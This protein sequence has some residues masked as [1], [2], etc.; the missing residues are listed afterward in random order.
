MMPKPLPLRRDPFCERPVRP[1]AFQPSP[2]HP[3]MAVPYRHGL[4]ARGPAGPIA[5]LALSDLALSDLA[6]SREE[7]LPVVPPVV[8]AVAAA[9]PPAA[10][11]ETGCG[12]I[13]VPPPRFL[14]MQP[15][16]PRRWQALLAI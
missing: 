5:D 16:P 7:R 11:P 13:S 1:A 8:L 14:V 10:E 12:P 2:V 3:S 4:N 6:L 9:I 15:E